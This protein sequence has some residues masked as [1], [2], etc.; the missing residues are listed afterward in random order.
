MKKTPVKPIAV[1]QVNPIYIDGKIKYWG[2]DVTYNGDLRLPGQKFLPNEVFG[3]ILNPVIDIEQ[4][5]Y[6]S[7]VK[8][9]TNTDSTKLSYSFRD[10]VFG[11]GAERA[12]QLRI[13][14]LAQITQQ[15]KEEN[16]R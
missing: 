14:M 11:R 6:V 15:K 5:C 9:D 1:S 8:Y 4:V 2:L 12:W 10:G 16:N 3:V 7:A 13:K